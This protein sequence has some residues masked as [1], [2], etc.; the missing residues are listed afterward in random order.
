MA[1]HPRLTPPGGALAAVWLAAV[2]MLPGRVSAQDP[3]PPDSIPSDSAQAVADSLAADTTEATVAIREPTFPARMAHLRGPS[4]E[5]FV[6]DRQC[7][8]SSSALTLL[9]LLIERVPGITG[10]RAEYFG[11]PHHAMDG[12]FGAGFGGL[13]I[14]GQPISP[15]ESGQADLRRLTLNYLEEVRVLRGADGLVIDASTSAHDGGEAYSRIN[16]ATG[17]PQLEGIEGVFANGFGDITVVETSFSLLNL[18][19]DDNP[20]DRFSALARVSVMPWSNRLGFQMEYR[21][22]TLKREGTDNA[23]LTFGSTTLRVRGNVGDNFQAEGFARRASRSAEIDQVIIEEDTIT[24]ESWASEAIGISAVAQKWGGTLT[25]AYSL[26][27]GLAQPRQQGSVGAWYRWGPLAAELGVEFRQLGDSLALDYPAPPLAPDPD[28]GEPDSGLGDSG[29]DQLTAT[30][31][32]YGRLSGSHGAISSSVRRAGLSFSDTLLWFPV[33]ARVFHAD[34]VQ[35]VPFAAMARAD[36]LPFASSGASLEIGLGPYILGGRVN[37][38][39]V[40]R[41]L[42]FGAVFDTAAFFWPGENEIKGWEAR[43][44]GPLIPLNL[45]M[46]GVNPIVLRGSWRRNTIVSGQPL[47]VPEN[48]G[49]IELLFNDTFFSG[50]LEIWLGGAMELR[51]TRIHPVVVA[52]ELEEGGEVVEVGDLVQMNTDSWSMAWFTFKIASFRFFWRVSNPSVADIFD[53]RQVFFPPQI[54][55]F[56]LRW[57]FHN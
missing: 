3:P 55:V 32:F 42:G 23:D 12:M 7:L 49:H 33:S 27:S 46:P 2:L 14:D 39:S 4:H 38:Q 36:T 18:A 19:R 11:G 37:R 22:G 30:A 29:D 6:C 34:G 5:V 15:M 1:A 45:M 47:Y 40:D 20:S 10:L 17:D 35:A 50:N 52:G 48:H 51:G 26:G 57:E 43:F 9:E 16:G 28:P 44:T 21:G 8:H 31:P 53:F 41:Q 13:Y 25:G 24:A 54:N 56:G